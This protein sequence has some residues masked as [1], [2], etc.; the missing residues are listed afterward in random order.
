VAL[1]GKAVFLAEEGE[2]LGRSQLSNQ[3]DHLAAEKAQA[4][5]IVTRLPRHQ[6]LT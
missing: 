3:L 5:V 6:L 4:A 2:D 1:L